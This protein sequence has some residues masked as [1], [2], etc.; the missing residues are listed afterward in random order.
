MKHLHFYKHFLL[1][2]NWPIQP[3]STWIAIGFSKSK[4]YT[5]RKLVGHALL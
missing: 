5:E 1:R 3:M 2:N 4:E